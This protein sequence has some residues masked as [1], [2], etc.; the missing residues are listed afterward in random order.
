MPIAIFKHFVETVF[1]ELA[2]PLD[3]V[4]TRVMYKSWT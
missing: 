2:T 1:A 4:Y 3:Q